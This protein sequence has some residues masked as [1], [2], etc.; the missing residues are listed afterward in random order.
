[1]IE[2]HRAS[3]NITTHLVEEANRLDDHVVGAARV[4]LDLGTRVR[5]AEAELGL[6]ERGARQ[7]LLVVPEVQPR[8]AHDL[9][10][11]VIR[12]AREV[13]RVLKKNNRT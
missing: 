13:E 2:H 6:R 8:A 1:M 11:R 9:S 7:L 10:H 3:P 4:E 5:V 12:A